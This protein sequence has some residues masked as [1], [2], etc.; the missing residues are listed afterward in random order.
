MADSEGA[1]QV[2]TGTQTTPNLKPARSLRPSITFAEQDIEARLSPSET[3]G[4][5]GGPGYNPHSPSPVLLDAKSAWRTRPSS[6]D[7][8]QNVRLDISRTTA[9]GAGLKSDSGPLR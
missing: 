3:Q 4:E 8:S 1:A 5:Q 9:G 7:Y 2:E 6:I